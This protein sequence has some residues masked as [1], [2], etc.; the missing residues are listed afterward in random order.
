MRSEEFCISC[1]VVDFSRSIPQMNQWYGWVTY[2]HQ[3]LDHQHIFAETGKLFGPWTG[4]LEK[5]LSW[6]RCAILRAFHRSFL[7]LW[8]WEPQKSRE[9]GTPNP[10]TQATYHKML[11]SAQELK[12]SWQVIIPK[13]SLFLFQNVLRSDSNPVKCNNKKRR[14]L[15]LC[16]FICNDLQSWPTAPWEL[17]NN[18][19]SCAAARNFDCDWSA[20]WIVVNCPQHGSF[21]GKCGEET[22][23]RYMM[24][25]YSMIVCL[26]SNQ[27]KGCLIL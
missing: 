5:W 9:P 7:N 20:A 21:T 22:T 4:R 23:P 2:L 24:F 26:V 11:V 10:R 1:K 8:C 12:P 13:N 6:L 27:F 16:F 19:R 15:Q 14:F 3:S 18:P 17:T 25:L